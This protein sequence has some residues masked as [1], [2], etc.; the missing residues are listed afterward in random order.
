MENNYILG[1]DG[2]LYHW[3]IKGM[4]WGVRRY[5]N[6]DGSLTEEGEKRYNRE[7]DKGEYNQRKADGTRFKQNRKGKVETLEFDAK[8]YAREDDEAVKGVVDA[9]RGMTNSL[10]QLNDTSIRMTKKNRKT[11]DLSNMT[12]KEMRDQINRAMLERQ[13]NDMFAPQKS[14]K[15][16]EYLNDVLDVAG[17]VLA[18]GASALSIAISVYTLRE[19]MGIK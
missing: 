6:K 12:D 15:G 11:M 8:K 5:Q 17:G 1:P 7:A 19:K 13:Y 18:V 16:R 3:G 2:E 10:K 14:T 9:S 4:K